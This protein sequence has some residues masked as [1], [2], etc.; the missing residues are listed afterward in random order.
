MAFISFDDLMISEPVPGFKVKFVHSEKATIAFWNITEG[1]VLPSHNH[2][3]EQ[4][5]IV[6]KGEL[7]L[8]IENKTQIMKPGMAAV[9]PSEALH[10]AKALTYCEV[11][12]IFSP[13]REDYK[14]KK[15]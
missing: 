4:I 8:T 5:T 2:I 7:E 13:V 12:D 11:T 6:T 3:H 15:I 14:H 10:S 9:I 1:S